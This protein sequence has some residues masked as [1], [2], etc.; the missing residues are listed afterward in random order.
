MLRPVMANGLWIKRRPT[1]PSWPWASSSM[2]WAST[3]SRAAVGS[4]PGNVC[5]PASAVATDR[6]PSPGVTPGTSGIA[7]PRVQIRV[8]DVGEEVEQDH[9]RR[10]DQQ[11]GE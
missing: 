4:M 8:D 10:R 9:E 7:D 6:L 11:V 1:V 2:P 5:A 3:E